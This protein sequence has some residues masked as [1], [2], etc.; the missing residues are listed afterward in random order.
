M[1]CANYAFTT[2]FVNYDYGSTFVERSI[3][4]LL[5]FEENIPPVKLANMESEKC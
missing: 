2:T 5:K 4:V 3:L 1:L